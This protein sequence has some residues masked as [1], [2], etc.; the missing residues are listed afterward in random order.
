MAPASSASCTSSGERSELADRSAVLPATLENIDQGLLTIDRELRVVAW[1]RNPVTSSNFAEEI[2]RAGRTFA[3]FVRFN[4]E[5]G[6]YGPGHPEDM[7]TVR[8]GPLGCAGR[9]GR[10][11]AADGPVLESAANRPRV[12][13][14]IIMRRHHGSPRVEEDGAGPREAAEAANRAKSEFLANM[15][16]EIRTPMNGIIGMTELVLET[17]LDA[18]QREYLSLVKASADALLS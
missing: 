13:D 17:E 3:D 12:G 11:A 18:E 5:R 10:A 7:M 16:H 6:E 2:V 9:S 1:N 14:F 8:V 4:A 15:S